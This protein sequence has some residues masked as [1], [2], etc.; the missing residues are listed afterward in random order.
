MNRTFNILLVEDDLV[1]GEVTVESLTM[2]GHAVTLVRDAAAAFNALS[3]EHTFDVILLDLRLGEERGDSIFDKLQLLRITYPPVVVLS[4]EHEATMRRAA[5]RIKTTH[6]LS[7]PASALQ[8]DSA[9][10]RAV[11]MT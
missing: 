8:I 3:V 4:A 7:K 6:V 2:L 1:L 10:H 11:T 9:M 5:E